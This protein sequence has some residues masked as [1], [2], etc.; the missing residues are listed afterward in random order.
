M[1]ESLHTPEYRVLL[2]TLAAV[3]ERS[4]ITQVMLAEKL[5]VTQSY[6][7][8]FERGERRLDL[9]Q[10]RHVCKAL[11]VGLVEFVTLFEAELKKS[12]SRR[13]G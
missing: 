9:V 6:V 13:S 11:G 8:K 3:R 12:R 1:S 2:I 4:G 5:G 10:L 7:S